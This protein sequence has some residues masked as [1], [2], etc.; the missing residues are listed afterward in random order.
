MEE[1]R[2]LHHREQHR[3]QFHHLQTLISSAQSTMM[4]LMPCSYLRW[5]R[6]EAPLPWQIMTTTKTLANEIDACNSD[7]VMAIIEVITRNTIPIKNHLTLFGL[8]PKN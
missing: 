4:R 7:L 1:F 2:Q 6:S 5:G 8:N 3:M